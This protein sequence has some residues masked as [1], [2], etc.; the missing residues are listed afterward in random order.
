LSYS[1]LLTT[2]VGVIGWGWIAFVVAMTGAGL[3][4][5]T[6]IPKATALDPPLLACM[7][8]VLGFIIT[9]GMRADPVG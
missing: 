4:L 1:V 5:G 6:T 2:L 8:F 3:W 7:G 9:V